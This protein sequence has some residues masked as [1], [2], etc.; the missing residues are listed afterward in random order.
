MNYD[1]LMD[2]CYVRAKVYRDSG[3]IWNLTHEEKCI[4]A[5]SE[6]LNQIKKIKKEKD[7]AVKTIETIM[8]NQKYCAICKNFNT[9]DASCK[10]I[11]KGEI[12]Y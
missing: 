12:L 11:W 1:N 4:S 10:P 9:Y 6:L 7:I 8:E 3:A 5:I 2:E